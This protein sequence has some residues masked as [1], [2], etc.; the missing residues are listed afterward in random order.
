MKK[1]ILSSLAFLILL[2]GCSKV[3]DVDSVRTVSEK[4]MWNTLE[5]ARAGLLG[6]YALSR[7]AMVDNNAHWLYGDVR[8][9]TFTSPNR[10]DLNAIINNSLNASFPTLDALSDW[11]RWFAVVNA[12]NL[13]IERVGDVK[14][15]DPRYSDTYLSIDV[16]QARFLRAFAYFYM[17]RIWGDVPL[18]ISSHDGQFD[19]LPRE[20][21]AKV[22]A[23]VEE[24]L[25]SASVKLPF[26]YSSNDPQQPGNYYNETHSRWLGTLATKNSAYAVLSH[27]AA[28]QGDYYST[29]VYTKFVIDNRAKSNIDYTGS[30]DL[31]A[32]GGLFNGRKDRHILGFNAEWGHNDGS[33]S[34]HIE[35]L[36]LAEPV[37]IKKMPDIYL[38][39]DTIL[40]LFNEQD[41]A[42]FNID[43][44]GNALST[45]YITNFN[46]KYPIF[47]KIKA[48]QGGNGDPN[49][50][51]FTSVALFTRYEDIVLLRAEALAVLGD[52]PG[53]T[54]MLN[55]IRSRRALANYNIDVNGDLIDA[56]FKERKRELIGEGHNW[57]D[58]IRY[59]RIKP[60]AVM[61]N[62]INSGGIYWPISKKVLNQNSLLTQNPYWN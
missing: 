35:E 51:Y 1:I 10:P 47:S 39:K 32:G 52:V 34:G 54:E 30:D 9:K 61:T 56:I 29:A 62:L 5:D 36:T 27:V 59:T 8:P 37:V 2:S 13:F 57:Y 50:R 49:F 14:K 42:R 3:L 43:T 22:L 31:V 16:A 6:I 7:A 26:I 4:N 41:D 25:L 11:T 19:K 60:R 18:I 40:A 33:T 12:A 23:W 48:I 55:N 53:A 15:A 46:G 20:K 45:R 28:W 24:E 38:P 21:Q 44:L 17:V 58:L